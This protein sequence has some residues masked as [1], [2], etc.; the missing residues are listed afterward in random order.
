MLRRDLLAAM[1]GLGAA[2]LGAA[3]IGGSA[4]AAEPAAIP[5]IPGPDPDTRTPSYRAPAGSVDTHT[6]IFGP[7]A[8]YPFA[9]KRPYSP[10]DAPLEMFRALHQ[11][12]GIDRAVIVNATVHG[13]DNRVVT[14]AIAQ[15]DGKYKGV[16][17]I[18]NEM[19]DTDLAAL[20]KAGICG[21]RFAFLRRLGGV[22]DMKLF[23]TLVDRV[24]AIGWHVDIYLEAGTIQEFVP[25]LK[26]L[27][28][29][30]VIDHMGTISAAKGLDDPEF[31]AL[32]DLQASDER[33]W[34]KITGPE[35]ASASGPPFHD[36]VPFAKRLIDNAPDRVIWGTDWPHPNVKFMPNDADL[37]DLIP[38][39]APDAEI[40][41]K[42]L[43][44][45]PERL[46]KFA[47]HANDKG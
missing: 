8:L 27:P 28:V 17:N 26:S 40:Q 5:T 21:C 6:H 37:V 38:L 15:S 16:A 4:F 18:N 20:D 47:P 23:R 7:A 31:K 35:R 12:I 43:V 25:I 14:D 32:L 41:H 44:Q 45:N 19:S 3:G 34:V 9:P 24:A 1:A 10:P 42:L 22:G 46:F 30:Y 11:K 13:T 29:T 2:G 36:A 39:Y 33:C